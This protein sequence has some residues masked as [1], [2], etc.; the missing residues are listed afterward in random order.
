MGRQ[1]R[2]RTRPACRRFCRGG[3][4]SAS[5]R[6]SAKGAAF[7]RGSLPSSPKLKIVKHAVA[8][9]V[10]GGAIW[11][12]AAVLYSAQIVS[13]FSCGSV[14][15]APGVGTAGYPPSAIRSLA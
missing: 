10:G 9:V 15:V 5:N 1:D 11:V 13:C 14:V 8:L 7:R 2:P 6:A 4:E 3:T 12:V